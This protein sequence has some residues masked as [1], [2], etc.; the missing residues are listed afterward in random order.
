L[1]QSLSFIKEFYKDH[2]KRIKLTPRVLYIFSKIIPFIPGKMVLDVG[3]GNKLITTAMSY[4]AK[5]DG[6]DLDSDITKHTPNCIYDI[7]TCFDVLEHLTDLVKAMQNII[8][9]CKPGGFVVINLPEQSD[10]SQPIDNLIY[11]PSLIQDVEKELKL[12]RLEWY[13]IGYNESYNY[14]VFRKR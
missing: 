1:S 6:I 9:A 11:V 10:K 2:A 14:I 8:Y 3:C 5:V 12:I 13:K 7:V 4:Y